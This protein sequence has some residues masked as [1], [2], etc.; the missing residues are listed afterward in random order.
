M[1]IFG[2]KIKN[3]EILIPANYLT[4]MRLMLS[5]K[6][7]RNLR[8]SLILKT[9]GMRLLTLY[10]VLALTIMVKIRCGRVMKNYALL[11]RKKC[12][13]TQR[14]YSQSFHLMLKRQ[15]KI[16]KSMRTLLTV[17]LKKAIPKNKC[18]YYLSGIYGLENRNNLHNCSF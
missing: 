6:K 12:S 13:Q 16:S 1:L 17:W 9:L 14:T 5:S 15:L 18:A 10:C 3:T 8:A 11:L 4:V 2:F 7:L